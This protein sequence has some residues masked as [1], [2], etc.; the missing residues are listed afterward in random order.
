MS[1]GRFGLNRGWFPARN[2]GVW[3]V[4]FRKCFYFGAAGM[5]SGLVAGG[6]IYALPETQADQTLLLIV[7][8]ASLA[9]AAA[10]LS[11]GLAWAAGAYFRLPRRSA[12]KPLLE[13]LIAAVCGAVGGLALQF[14]YT[15]PLPLWVQ[16]FVF[17]AL[18]WGLL[19]MVIVGPVAGRLPNAR[20]GTALAWSFGA[21]CLGGLLYFFPALLIPDPIGSVLGVS[22]AGFCIGGSVALA[23]LGTGLAN[24]VVC[25]PTGCHTVF[26]LG[27]EPIYIGGGQDHVWLPGLKPRSAAILSSHGRVKFFDPGTG[28]QRD[29]RNLSKLKVGGV[30]LIVHTLG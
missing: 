18:L 14:L 19:A 24:V 11:A 5:I 3:K 27:P 21:G 15:T 8:A 20:L 28:K 26:G 12:R 1:R 2:D 17:K 10:F 30:E 9:L 29:M 16:E 25:W 6:L 23:D 4:L 7:A 22:L 13:V